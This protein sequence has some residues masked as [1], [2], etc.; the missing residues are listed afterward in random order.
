MGAFSVCA[1]STGNGQPIERVLSPTTDT[2]TC[3]GTGLD[4][5]KKRCPIYNSWCGVRK[6]SRQRDFLNTF[7]KP[8]P[9]MS[10]HTCLFVATASPWNGTCY[11]GKRSTLLWIGNL[12][13]APRAAAREKEG[14]VRVIGEEIPRL[15]AAFFPIIAARARTRTQQGWKC[16]Y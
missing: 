11:S 7:K 3:V 9:F 1:G 15:A 5:Q 13:K 4:T 10:G 16:H 12:I 6:V 8:Y 2:H 14:N